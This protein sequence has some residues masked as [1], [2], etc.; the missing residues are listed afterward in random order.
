MCAVAFQTISSFLVRANRNKCAHYLASVSL[1]AFLV[2]GAPVEVWYRG[3]CSF[4]RGCLPERCRAPQ[5]GRTPL[6]VASESGH[7]KVVS[8]LLA[9]GADKNAKDGVRRGGR[10]EGPR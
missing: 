7:V 8:K 6:H 10:D 4:G 9:V 5:S 3:G 2:G 1:G